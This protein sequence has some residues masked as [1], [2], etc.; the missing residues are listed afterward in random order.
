MEPKPRPQQHDDR[1][2]SDEAEK[3]GRPV[4]VLH[5]LPLQLCIVKLAQ[6]LADSAHVRPTLQAATTWWARN[7]HTGVLR[8]LR[9]VLHAERKIMQ[10]EYESRFFPPSKVRH[11]A[12]VM[13]VCTT[14]TL[15]GR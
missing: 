6:F 8:I 12:Y 1:N 11:V 15:T 13:L 2:D 10:V 4:V 14:H 7:T 5:K 9:L 3:H